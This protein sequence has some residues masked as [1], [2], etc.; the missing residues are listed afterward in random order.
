MKDHRPKLTSARKFFVQVACFLAV[1]MSAC[2]PALNWRDVRPAGTSLVG[3]LPCKPELGTRAVS[4]GNK[5]VTISMMA[6]DANGATF[7]MA[8]VPMQDASEATALLTQW[9]VATI[10]TMR[11][12][13]LDSS[14]F[15]LKGSSVQ[16]AAVQV[17]ATGVRPDGRPVHL[18]AVWFAGAGQVFQ[19]AMYADR[20]Q[21]EMAEAFFAGLRLP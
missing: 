5:V 6:C 10:S 2:S 7:T 14:P 21:P 4:L 15:A 13:T 12:Q 3:L 11:G 18:Q 9:R 20:R 1:L 17:D 8:H 16:P 19:V